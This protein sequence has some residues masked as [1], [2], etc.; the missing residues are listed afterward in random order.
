[1]RSER[2]PTTYCLDI[3]FILVLSGGR[4]VYLYTVFL[5]IFEQ[6]TALTLMRDDLM[7]MSE[8]VEK[9]FIPINS[10][11]GCGITFCSN[12]IKLY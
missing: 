5:I 4:R 12:R 11:T 9:V 2:D 10:G 1:M 3:C 8:H 6:I 7:L